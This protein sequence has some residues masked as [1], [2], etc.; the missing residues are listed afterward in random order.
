MPLACVYHKTEK[1]RVVSFDE[2]ERL[3]ET[4]QWFKHPNDVNKTITVEETK[5]EEP[6]RRGRRKRIIDSEFKTEKT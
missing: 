6:I 1:M 5:H 4:G 3:L 2:R